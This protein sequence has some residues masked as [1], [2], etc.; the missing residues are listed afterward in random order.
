[1]IV[2]MN[3]TLNTQ[4]PSFKKWLMIVATVMFMLILLPWLIPTAQWTHKMA[5]TLEEHLKQPVT[6]Q[7]IS[8]RVLPRP[9]IKVHAF[10]VG[11]PTLF[12]VDDVII[13]PEL[14]ALV[15]GD[16]S[17]ANVEI[18]HPTVSMEAI[19]W[20]QSYMSAST[21]KSPAITVRVKHVDI[22]GATLIGSGWQPPQVNLQ[23]DLDEHAQLRQAELQT[24]APEGESGQLRV[25][26]RPKSGGYTAQFEGEQWRL[27]MALPVHVQA[28]TGQVEMENNVIQ[29]NLHD[30]SLFGGHIVANARI[31]WGESWTIGG[32]AKVQNLSL[33][34]ALSS[35]TGQATLTGLLDGHVHFD[36]HMKSLSTLAEAV[37]AKGQFAI[38]KGVIHGVDL[39]KLASVLITKNDGQGNTEFE[40]LKGQLN[41]NGA[42]YQLNP[43]EIESGLIHGEGHVEMVK[44]VLRGRLNIEV[45]RSASLVAVPLNVS[46]TLQSP[47]I[48]PTKS[49]MAGAAIGTAVLGPGVGTSVGIKVGD[50]LN[51]LKEGLFGKQK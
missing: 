41:V 28:L 23:L 44:S 22:E 16:I 27:P 40:T 25:H 4:T 50:K 7:S 47:E 5:S 37:R 20:V 31:D 38:K 46:G 15:Q 6:I 32:D 19:S 26:V 12:S 3:I 2:S 29:L 11:Q 45:K 8:I 34:S 13:Y 43:L 30:A 42:R 9:S 35:M 51:Q 18:M 24:I 17:M 39:L 1:M 14:W 33:G 36:A 48:S 21:G 49:A 10:Q